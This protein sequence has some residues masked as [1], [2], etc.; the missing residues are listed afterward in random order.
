MKLLGLRARRA[1]SR[2]V[3][4][5]LAT[6][7]LTSAAVSSAWAVDVVISSSTSSTVNLDPLQSGPS[8]LTIN[9]GVTVT[10]PTGNSAVIATTAPW[11]VTNSGTLNASTIGV[12]TLVLLSGGTVVNN[13]G[14]S[15]N[16][17]ASLGVFISGGPGV[18]TNRGIINSVRSGVGIGEGM[19][20]STLVQGTVTNEAGGRITSIDASGII[21]QDPGS[22]TVTNAGI[23]EGGR[24]GV[25]IWTG[26]INNNAGGIIRGTNTSTFSD[27]ISVF[28]GVATIN[29]AGAITGSSFYAATGTGQGP[30]GLGS[31]G[32]NVDPA[33]RAI[34]NNAVGGQ[35]TATLPSIYIRSTATGTAGSSVTNSGLIQTTG[36]GTTIFF[37]GGSGVVT[38]NA[39][40]TIA[41]ATAP[42]SQ[43]AFLT[44]AIA[45]T[46]A[47][48]VVT[49]NGTIRGYVLLATGGTITNNTGARIEG[50][51]AVYNSSTATVLTTNQGF[52]GT[53]TNA[54]T[55]TGSA[56][57]ATLTNTGSISG[58][59]LG[60]TIIN[61]GA[62]G[63][64]LSMTTGNDSL[65]LRTGS[66]IG[67]TIDAGT[68]TD[69]L[70]LE[71]SGTAANVFTGFENLT[72]RGTEW[73]LSGNS[74]F[75]TVTVQSGFLN[76]NGTLTGGPIALTAAGSGIRGAGRIENSV[77]NTAGI[78][79]PGGSG[80]V[81]TLTVAGNYTHGSTAR[82][83]IDANEAG[84]GDRLTVTGT[85]QLQG[86]TLQIAA[87]D[88]A[89]SVARTYTVL[90][91]AGGLTGQFGATE[92]NLQYLTPT[93]A[94]SANAVTLSLSRATAEIQQDI[95]KETTEQQISTA[96]RK[97]TATV[98]SR[99]DEV[100]TA[101]FPMAQPNG[102]QQTSM[103][104]A[105]SYGGI[106]SL[107]AGD[108]MGG[109]G[110]WATLAPTFV[111]QD[112]ILPGQAAAQKVDGETWDMFAGVDKLVGERAVVGALTGFE[113]S[114]YDI[115][116]SNGER[117]A[118]GPMLAAY[119]GLVLTDWLYATAQLNHA[120]FDNKL[121]ESS[122]NSAAVSGKFDSRR[123]TSSISMTGRHE[124]DRVKL[125][126]KVGY[127]YTR[128]TFDSYRA[129]DGTA[130]NPDNTKLGR[131]T[132][133]G[134]A[135]Y[136]G[137]TVMPYVLASFERD[138]DVNAGPGEREGFVLGGGARISAERYSLDIYGNT[139][140]G[141]SGESALSF[142]LNVRM[143][144]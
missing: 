110:A 38:N 58:N 116:G 61:A 131:V 125:S 115:A 107:A 35:I 59:V 67:G 64:N 83:I 74:T 122:F 39:G 21:Y 137:E 106:T 8:T 6:T 55:I 68:G 123:F 2:S 101:A 138:V 102:D 30:A 144:F 34:I 18:V 12:S 140:T 54:G 46:G 86:G 100:V 121:T 98:E 75:G 26:T 77:T 105:P 87:V 128:E 108:D 47:N 65:T 37:E 50:T 112:L 23:I 80:T 117:R 40:G 109:W 29:N 114:D 10:A 56:G 43:Y 1:L 66:S 16:N 93:L 136:R 9:S 97:T 141:R 78:V 44:G 91:A 48:G 82:L 76:V 22:L 25:L 7:A 135:A 31:F 111:N 81:G 126:G 95:V 96:T 127:S 17:T 15:I 85:A 36:A 132:I 19:G 27:A 104:H 118:E 63:G 79:T 133:G 4:I 119:A 51:A 20:G 52:S 134:E 139:E 71:G 60:S 33:G 120:W 42:P 92:L 124:V 90:S 11:T 13:A 113:T 94:Y 73:T 143:A 24:Q 32:I 5:L 69:T 70:F 41:S 103:L 142:G 53:L 57:A 62:I 49:N 130:V 89:W 45:M 14:G 72:M 84:Q 129:S 99:I 3:P 88:G 28:N